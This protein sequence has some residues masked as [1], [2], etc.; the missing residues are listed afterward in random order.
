MW[1]PGTYDPALGLAYFGVAQTYD[2]GPLRIPVN[3]P[4]IT[5]DGLY[6]DSTVAINPDT[7]KVAWYF[8]HLP[9]D[10]WDLDW[11]FEHQ[12]VKL[13]VNGQD[14]TVVIVGGKVAMYDALDA[15]TGKFVFSYDSGLQNIITAVDP[16]TG[17]KKIDVS[18]VPG[19]GEVK[20]VCPHSGGAK[21]W[22]AAS[23][24]PDTN[25]LFTPLVESCMDLAPTPPGGRASLSSGVNWSLRPRP[26]SDGKLGRL[27][28]VNLKTRKRV[29]MTRDRAPIS[30][31]VLDTAGG[32]VFM[33]TNDRVIHAYDDATG[34]EIWQTRLNDL[35]SSSP[36]SYAVNGKQ[37]LAVVVGGGGAQ[38]ATFPV[39]TPELVVPTDRTSSIW[40]FAL[41]DKYTKSASSR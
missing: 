29:W 5:N 22:L 16:V 40:V 26:G 9:N 10:Q 36:I 24:N 34:R 18:K 39:L 17:A 12:L 25:L 21:S 14:R 13:P 3:Q 11:I 28:A 15:Q 20:M 33:G 1:V 27:E 30:S 31:S 32:V 6:T 41:P 2:T 8:Q 38:A 23:Y 4:G 19:D 7:G 35:P 37:Y